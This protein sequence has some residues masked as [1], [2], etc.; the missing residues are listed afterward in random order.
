MIRPFVPCD[1]AGLA[2]NNMD[3]VRD[4]PER[5][6]EYGSLKTVGD[7][8]VYKCWLGRVDVVDRWDVA[9]VYVVVRCL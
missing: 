1:P 3:Y 4:T 5:T 7:V 6:L 9:V 2:L 8:V